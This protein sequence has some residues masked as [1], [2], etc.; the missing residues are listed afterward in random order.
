MTHGAS[1]NI[2]EWDGHARACGEVFV[3]RKGSRVAVCELWTHPIGGE[4]RVTVGGELLRSEAKRDGMALVNIGL[5]WREQ[6]KRK[7]WH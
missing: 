3:L 4:V 6:F 7:G 2:P 1:I 5:E